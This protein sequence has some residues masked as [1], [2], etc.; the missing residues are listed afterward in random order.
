MIP[1]FLHLM[2]DSDVAT[3]TLRRPPLNIM[4]LEMVAELV[5]AIE[6]LHGGTDLRL[7]VIAAEGKAFSAGVDVADHAADR[8]ER[9][10][11]LVTRKFQL[12]LKLECPTLAVVQGAALGGGC[13][14]ALAC[15]LVLAAEEA[16]FGLPEISLGVWAPVAM[17]LLPRLVGLRRA[18]ALLLTGARVPATE[19]ERLGLITAAVPGAQL[20][21]EA[22]SLI[23]T[24]RD[25]SAPVL[26]SCKAAVREHLDQPLAEAL[27]AVGQQYLGRL[28]ALEDPHEGL[29]AFL[30]KRRP[31]WHQR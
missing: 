18:L 11:A 8:V 15:D 16:V 30:E 12:L 13:E 27:E 17:V 25:L 21:D 10:I 1:E 4:T 2:R 5:Q 31:R 29:A 24:L 9:M 3:L 6:A 20:G 28:M 14:L 26:R 7:L 23:S 22:A 19:A